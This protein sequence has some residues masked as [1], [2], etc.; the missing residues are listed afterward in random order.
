[1]QTVIGHRPY[2]I[3]HQLRLAEVAGDRGALRWIGE[4]RRNRKP[5]QARPLG[6]TAHQGMVDEFHQP[7]ASRFV[8]RLDENCPAAPLPGF[9]AGGGL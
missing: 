1:V 7:L 8:S 4:E 6:L 9:L 3:E 5:E 2:G